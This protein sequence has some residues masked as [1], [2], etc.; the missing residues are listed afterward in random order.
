[1]Q[2]YREPLGA[3]R[4]VVRRLSRTM[5]KLYARSPRHT[6]VRTSTEPLC[7]NVDITERTT[8]KK[9]ENFDRT[10]NYPRMENNQLRGTTIHTTY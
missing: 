7:C 5:H 3:Q 8:K 4:V 9:Y 10:E 6:P 2:A 1:M